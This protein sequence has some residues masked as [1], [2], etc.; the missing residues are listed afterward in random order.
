M[1]MVADVGERGA[2]VGVAAQPRW[3]A[4]RIGYRHLAASFSTGEL[5]ILVLAVFETLR[6]L[7]EWSYSAAL[8]ELRDQKRCDCTKEGIHRTFQRSMIEKEKRK[9]QYHV[10]SLTRD[11]PPFL[12]PECETLQISF[13]PVCRKCSKVP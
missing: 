4:L 5:A 13:G 7:D 12:D 11:Q 1:D 2:L 9:G 3:T 10:N 6:R 8:L